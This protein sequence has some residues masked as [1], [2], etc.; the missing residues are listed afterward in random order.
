VANSHFFA[1][2]VAPVPKGLQTTGLYLRYSSQTVTAYVASSG[3]LIHIGWNGKIQKEALVVTKV[4]TWN[5]PG[6]TTKIH[7]RLSDC[8]R[9]PGCDL[10]LTS[11]EYKFRTW[12]LTGLFG[13]TAVVTS[14]TRQW[15]WRLVGGALTGTITVSELTCHRELW[16]FTRK[17][18]QLCCNRKEHNHTL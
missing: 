5:F 13:V 9:W 16:T 18:Y 2:D 14:A 1:F 15:I 4:V 17:Q 8:S 11:S 6:W 12:P 10:N 7:E 3:K